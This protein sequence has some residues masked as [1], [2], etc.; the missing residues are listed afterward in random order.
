MYAANTVRRRLNSLCAVREQDLSRQIHHFTDYVRQDTL[1][2]KVNADDLRRA[3]QQSA[4]RKRLIRR[5]DGS[6]VATT[7]TKLRHWPSALSRS[8]K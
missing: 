8:R 4:L 6:K 2:A 5:R 3:H 7:E 1:V